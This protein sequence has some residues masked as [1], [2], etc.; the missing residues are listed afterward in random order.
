MKKLFINHEYSARA[1]LCFPRFSQRFVFLDEKCHRIDDKKKE[2]FPLMFKNNHGN[3]ASERTSDEKKGKK[4]NSH[5]IFIVMLATL[6]PCLFSTMHE[7]T[8]LS[9]RFSPLGNVKAAVVISTSL[10]SKRFQ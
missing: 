5:K 6:L 9:V 2:S 7:Y 4:K 8:P 10:V 3:S 1:Y